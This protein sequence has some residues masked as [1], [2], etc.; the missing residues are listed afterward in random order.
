MLPIIGACSLEPS[1]P[2]EGA[3]VSVVAETSRARRVVLSPTDASMATYGSRGLWRRVLGHG[4]MVTVSIIFSV[5]NVLGERLTK[6][7]DGQ[8]FRCPLMLAAYRELGATPL[9]AAGNPDGLR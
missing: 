2:R 6:R 8:S 5:W 7:C 3:A 9:H 4:A 1:S